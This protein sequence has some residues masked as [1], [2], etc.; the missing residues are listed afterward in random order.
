MLY[1]VHPSIGITKYR[2][3]RNIIFLKGLFFFEGKWAS[4]AG[5][6]ESW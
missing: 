4:G 1:L 2:N 6:E 3:I 5:G